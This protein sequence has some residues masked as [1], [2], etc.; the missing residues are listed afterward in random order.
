M[1]AVELRYGAVMRQSDGSKLTLQ[2][3]YRFKEGKQLNG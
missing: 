3:N 2:S 1:A